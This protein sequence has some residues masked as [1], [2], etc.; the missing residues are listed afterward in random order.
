MQ[1]KFILNESSDPV[2]PGDIGIYESLEDLLDYVEAIDVRNGEY[3]AFTSDGRKITLSAD[4][5][6][7]PISANISMTASS[8]KHVEL[9]L[10]EYLGRLTE[11]DRFGLSQSDINSV[12]SLQELVNLIPAT[13][14]RR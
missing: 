8:A 13:I 5:H 10:T 4:H 6:Y 9:L 3:F 1:R 2:R 12:S 7:A 11:D 14:V